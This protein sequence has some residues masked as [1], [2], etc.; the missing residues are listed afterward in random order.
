M[1]L[2]LARFKNPRPS[3]TPPE[4]R[5]EDRVRDFFEGEASFR[6]RATALVAASERTL[7]VFSD[8]LDPQLYDDRALCDAVV[9]LASRHPFCQVYILV[10]DSSQL[11]RQFHRLVATHQR[12][13]SSVHLRKLNPERD[14]DF[15]DYMV[16]DETGVLRLQEPERYQGF[17]CRYE[18]AEA[19]RLGNEFDALWE[20]SLA[21]PDIRQLTNL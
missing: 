16:A 13:T 4:V 19:R 15:N 3:A 12:L 1:T 10:R 11:G 2:D 14:S 9:D 5:D 8:S 7:R 20:S 21:D 17:S 18:P 6:D